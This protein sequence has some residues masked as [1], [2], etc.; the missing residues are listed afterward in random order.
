MACMLNKQL[1]S[2]QPP[3]APT[4]AMPLLAQVQNRKQYIG[5]KEKGTISLHSRADMAEWVQGHAFPLTVAALNQLPMDQLLV[6]PGA[7]V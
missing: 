1:Y 5:R 7:C 4:R 2:P 3:K 6:L